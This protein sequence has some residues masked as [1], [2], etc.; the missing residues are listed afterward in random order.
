MVLVVVQSGGHARRRPAASRGCLLHDGDE[1][2]ARLIA[3]AR[4][5]GTGFPWREP[6]RPWL[7]PYRGVERKN[8]RGDY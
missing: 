7:D 6:L 5:R 3:N 1:H 8:Y 4:R 2:C